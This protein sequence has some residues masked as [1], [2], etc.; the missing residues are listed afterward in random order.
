[1]KAQTRGPWATMVHSSNSYES[2]IQ[3]LTFQLQ[4]QQIKMSNLHKLF[5]L[6]GGLLN[7]Q[8]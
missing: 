6:S 7:K 4:W 3:R 1:M 5:M 2:L 8:F